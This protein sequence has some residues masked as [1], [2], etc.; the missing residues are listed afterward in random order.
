MV[1]EEAPIILRICFCFYL[2]AGIIYLFSVTRL[3]PDHTSLK[4]NADGG[5][6]GD[7]AAFGGDKRPQGEGR[8][9]GG[10]ISHSL[11]PG[12]LSGL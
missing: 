7:T 5:I 12:A 6:V 9:C 1:F 2:P 11:S 8:A 10:G 3:N 4:E